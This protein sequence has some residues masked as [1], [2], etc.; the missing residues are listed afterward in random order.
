[1][2][3]CD[4]FRDLRLDESLEL[5]SEDESGGHVTL[6]RT[7]L[8]SN[9]WLENWRCT[10]KRVKRVSLLCSALKRETEDGKRWEG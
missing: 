2:R 5:C 10:F 3:N 4:G 6:L 1:M 8:C 7:W 9:I